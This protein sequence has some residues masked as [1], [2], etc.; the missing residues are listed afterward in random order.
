MPPSRDAS[1]GHVWLVGAGPGDPGLLTIAA[2]RALSRA[3]VVLYD[4]LAPAAVLR[5]ARPEARIEYVGKRAGAQILPQDEI[6][7]QMVAYAQEGL[8]VVR[9]KGGDPLVFGRGGEEALALKKAGVPF[10]II[11]GI[12]SALAALAYA[13]IPVTHRGLAASFMVVT[14][15]E[16]DDD[17]GGAVD[18]SAAARVDT[19]VVLMGMAS[20]A[21]IARRLMSAGRSGGTPAA[22]VRWGTRPDQQVV[23]ATLASI[24]EASRRAGVSSPAVIVVGEVASLSEQLAWFVPGPLAGHSVVVTRARASSSSLAELLEA[25]GARVIEAPA[26]AIQPRQD[27]ID[28]E[29]VGSRWDWVVFGSQNAVDA[30][31]E[32]LLATGRDARSLGATK[33][34]AVGQATARALAARGLIADFIPS[35]GTSEVLASELE[36]VSGARIFLPVSNL[37]NQRLADALRRRGALVEQII[38]YDTVHQP[39]SGAVLG[40]ILQAD[41]IT[42]ASGSAARNLRAALGEAQVRA[43]ARLISIGPEASKAVAGAFGRVDRE[44]QEPSIDALVDA[45]AEELA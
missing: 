44:A 37:T 23:R 18:W 30:F 25:L 4:A 7:S 24:A 20:L 13:G 10:T 14:G 17:E 36:S 9:L 38:A 28:D 22:V 19:L 21:T 42:F 8:Q 16:A 26:I 33:I 6:E 27:L 41:A 5:H 29:R 2:A 15:S 11:P 39:L 1:T 40:D 34:A 45:V 31:F 35:R 32:A 12:T 43:D 3:D